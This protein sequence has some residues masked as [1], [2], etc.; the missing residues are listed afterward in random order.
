[1]LDQATAGA[2]SC[3]LRAPCLYVSLYMLRFAIAG[4]VI[5]Q[6]RAPN[7]VL[8][9]CFSIL[10]M[11]LGQGATVG[12]GSLD[13][14]GISLTMF[15]TVGSV[16]LVKIYF[17]DQPENSGELPKCLARNFMFPRPSCVGKAQPLVV[18]DES[19]C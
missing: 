19:Q 8:G 14:G 2:W 4:I 17:F 16:H 5:E 13:G 15:A 9:V 10:L 12:I 6:I 7:T 3:H 18:S 1:M 11:G